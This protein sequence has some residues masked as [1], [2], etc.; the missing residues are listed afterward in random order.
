M[1]FNRL[2]LQNVE[3]SASRIKWTVHSPKRTFVRLLTNPNSAPI[4]DGVELPANQIVHFG[5]GHSYFERSHG[6]LQWV[7]MSLPVEE[8][9]ADRILVAGRHITL[10]RTLSRL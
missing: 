8:P 2:W 3:E 4:L 9:T 1:E 6:P 7:G 10:P 5:N